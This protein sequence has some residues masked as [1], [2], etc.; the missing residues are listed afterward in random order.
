MENASP[1]PAREGFPSPLRLIL[2]RNMLVAPQ[3]F[4]D[5]YAYEVDWVAGILPAHA[6][7]TVAGIGRIG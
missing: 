3:Q 7:G 4:G 5:N 2:L 1:A 6:G